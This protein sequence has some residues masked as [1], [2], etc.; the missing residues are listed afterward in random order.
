MLVNP[1]PRC[2]HDDLE[3]LLVDRIGPAWTPF[4]AVINPEEEWEVI[5]FEPVS[6]SRPLQECS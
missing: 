4:A 6:E 2:N 1:H 5:H 3:D